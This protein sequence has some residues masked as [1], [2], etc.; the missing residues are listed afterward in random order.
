MSLDLRK[1][2]HGA[3][4]HLADIH[5][6]D[7]RCECEKPGLVRDSK[8]LFLLHFHHVADDVRAKTI[9]QALTWLTMHGKPDVAADLERAF[10][11]AQ[12]KSK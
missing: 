6:C 11:S 4:L 8:K 7:C 5:D 1:L 12:G 10:E 3:A 2:A 9:E